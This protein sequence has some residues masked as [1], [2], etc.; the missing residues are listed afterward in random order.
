MQEFDPKE[1]G[2]LMLRQLM[3]E[4]ALAR[5]IVKERQIEEVIASRKPLTTHTIR[6]VK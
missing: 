3:A 4:E 2:R 1:H 6:L 5:A